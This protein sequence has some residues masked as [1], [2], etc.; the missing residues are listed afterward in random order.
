MAHSNFYPERNTSYNMAVSFAPQCSTQKKIDI[1]VTS[2]P[3]HGRDGT[4]EEAGQ[5]TG[6]FIWQC[7]YGFVNKAIIMQKKIMRY[8]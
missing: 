4:V 3:Q 2:N 8:C 1:T 6:G 5:N 7:S